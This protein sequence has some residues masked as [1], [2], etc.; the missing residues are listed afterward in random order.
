MSD[1][2]T[3]LI[4]NIKQVVNVRTSLTVRK[5]TFLIVNIKQLTEVNIDGIITNLHSS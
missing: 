2:F 4:V 1:K 3:F 5:F